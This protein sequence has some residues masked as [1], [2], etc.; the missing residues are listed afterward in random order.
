[1]S[2]GNQMARKARSSRTAKQ[3]LQKEYRA[4]VAEYHRITNYLK[5]ATGILSKHER[6]FLKEYSSLPSVNRN[7]C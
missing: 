1:M 6:E 7:V 2:Q 4:A 5:A 3:R